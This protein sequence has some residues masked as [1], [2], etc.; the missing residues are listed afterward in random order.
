MYIFAITLFA[1][2]CVN[3]DNLSI[4]TDDGC[5]FA[6][7]FVVIFKAMNYQ[8][9]RKDIMKLLDDMLKC[10]DE[11]CRFSDVDYVREIIKTYQAYN[12][13]IF[14]GFNV[15]GVV[16]GVALLF[17][18]PVEND[19][20]IRAQYPFDTAIS[21]WHEIGFGIE[22]FAVC[23]GLL[24]IIAMDSITVTMCS[25]ITALFYIVNVNFEN[26]TSETPRDADKISEKY[27]CDNVVYNGKK[28]NNT[29]LYRYKTYLRL[30]QRLVSVTNDYNKTYSSSMF[31]QMLSSTSM[32]CLTGFQAVVVG[33]QS[34][35]IM[36]FGIYLTAA[37][38]Q[39]L[40]VCWIGNELNYSS[41]V[42]DRSLWL[43]GWHHERLTNIAQVF[44]LS[45]MSSRQSITLKAGVFY[46]LSLQTFI[47]IIR[48]SYS[49]FTLLNN[50][51]VVNV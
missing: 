16:L 49:I 38:S 5:I 18:S 9:R 4:A 24:G 48:R 15:L 8:I 30:H 2:I 14:Y 27:R 23:G 29:F 39:L 46:V 26:C 37:I 17:F 25:F 40:Y 19:L 20:P 6:G 41:S 35:D 45:T 22:T 42:L 1:D 11:L 34:S 7:I 13:V 51:H 33:G 10:A 47:T 32:I 43:S 44:T 50:M 12:K 28:S 31:V 36:K 21:P 3:M